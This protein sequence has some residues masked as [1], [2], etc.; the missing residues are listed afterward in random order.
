M[1]VKEF[2]K[3]ETVVKEITYSFYEQDKKVDE[4]LKNKISKY[5]DETY[6][7]DKN[8]EGVYKLYVYNDHQDW[9]AIYEI[10][11][12]HKPKTKEEF[13]DTLYD[14]AFEGMITATDILENNLL[15]DIKENCLSDDE[16][17]YLEDVHDWDF[18]NSIFEAQ[19]N[20][21]DIWDTV[22]SNMESI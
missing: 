21:N 15:M 7:Y 12:S 20:F 13:V 8:K 9:K 17:S 19:Y 1:N 10:V 2:E 18:Y 14:I 5:I 3:V 16:V 11:D 22:K 4:F 6:S